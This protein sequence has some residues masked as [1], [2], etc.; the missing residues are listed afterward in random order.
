MSFATLPLEVVSLIVDEVANSIRDDD[1]R[2]ETG[3]QLALVCKAWKEL[4]LDA[5]WRDLTLKADDEDDLPPDC[6]LDGLQARARIFH[7]DLDRLL[8]SCTRL[9]TIAANLPMDL[10]DSLDVLAQSDGAPRLRHLQLTTMIRSPDELR[11]RL[12][13]LSSFPNFDRLALA[14]ATVPWDGG[15]PC[16]K[17][18]SEPFIATTECELCFTGDVNFV[19]DLVLP[20]LNRERLEVLHIY[21]LQYS[22]GFLRHLPSFDHMTH[23]QLR[24]LDGPLLA[25]LFPLL[26]RTLTAC[27]SLV[28]LDIVPVHGTPVPDAPPA[29][30]S[31]VSLTSFFDAFPPSLRCA[32]VEDLYFGHDKRVRRGMPSSR[33]GEKHLVCGFIFYKDESHSPDV[34]R[35]TLLSLTDG[36]GSKEYLVGPAPKRKDGIAG[37]QAA[38]TSFARNATPGA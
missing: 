17:P 24:A 35:A 34:Q 36:D 1:E 38:V 31:P 3:V 13:P 25:S 21:L 10:F 12:A 27:T 18:A 6:G 8:A 19:T 9:N 29:Q 26:T 16:P 2:R 28:S 11:L 7:D 23:L 22:E 4:G 32:V 30:L 5:A 15:L 20:A 14:F 33:H 37:E